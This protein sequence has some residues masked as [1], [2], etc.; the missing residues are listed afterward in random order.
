MK[1]FI[2]K[3]KDYGTGFLICLGVL[4]SGV[5]FNVN[6]QCTSAPYGLYGSITPACTG[7]FETITTCG[8]RGEYSNV[9]VIAGYQYEFQSSIS[10]DYVTIATTSNAPLVWGTQSVVWTATFTGTVRFFNHVNSSC[11]T[12]TSCMTRSVK[13]SGSAGAPCTNNYAYGS[14]SAPSNQSTVTISSCNYQNEYSTVSNLVQ[15]SDYQVN[16]SN[17]GYITVRH[18]AY[19]GTVVAHGPAPL[20]FT[21]T[22]SGTY[23]IHYNTDEFCGTATTCGTT[24]IKCISCG[25]QYNPCLVINDL[26]CGLQEDFTINSGSGAWSNYGGPVVTPGKEEIFRYTPSVSATY[27]LD[28]TS[29]DDW[30]D[31]FYKEA[32][33]GCN[34]AG[35]AY[36]GRIYTQSSFSVAL[37]GGVEYYFMLD[38]ESSDEVPFTVQ[39]GC[40]P[41]NDLC[42]NARS[43]N[44]GCGEIYTDMGST[45]SASNSGA[46][47]GCTTSASTAPGVWYRLLGRGTPLNVSLCGSSFDTKLFVYSGECGNLNCVAGNDNACGV[48]S[49]LNFTSVS[50]ALYY[51]YVTGNNAQ[52]GNY[53]LTITDG[54]TDSEAPVISGDS[55]V[56]PGTE[57]TLTASGGFSGTGADIYWYAQPNG[58]GNILEIGSSLTIVANGTQTFYARREG[59]CNVSGDAMFTVVADVP[60][61][62][63]LDGDSRTCVVNQNGFV[64]FSKDGRLIASVNSHG[65]NLGNV[66]SV[67]YVHGNPIDVPAC[68]NPLSPQFNT[69]VLGRSWLISP[70]FQPASDVTVRLYLDIDE[71][72]ELESQAN[73]NLSEQDDVLSIADLQLSKY[74]NEVVPALENNSPLDNC[75][76]GQTTAHAQLAWDQANNYFIGFDA[77]GYY[78][79]YDIPSFSEFWL[80]GNSTLSPLPVSLTYFDVDCSSGE[81]EIL[82]QTVSENNSDYFSVLRSNDGIEWRELGRIDA[83][84]TSNEELNYRTTD[85][86]TM[87]GIVY[88]K[89]IQVDLDGEATE[90]GPVSAD[91]K[92]VNNDMSIS[93]YPNPANENTL[94]KIENPIRGEGRISL[95]DIS[96][97]A[98][99]NW[100]VQFDQTVYVKSVSCEDFASG[101][102]RVWVVFPDGSAESVIMI[103]N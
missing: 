85:F 64:H 36:L 45:Y 91:C 51:I 84:G 20:S 2:Q 81:A 52:S 54:G 74:H 16:N 100:E 34:A 79:E 43:I 71:Y 90:Y 77:N 24:T 73:I 7:N 66:T 101:A 88:Y 42:E 3:V 99:M 83:A 102:Y 92:V 31:L 48:Q 75:T 1:A 40:P 8:Y 47:P 70:D 28:I 63:G 65:Q 55:P 56:C 38:A 59:Y 41:V 13:C 46:G 37:T 29:A 97:R 23:Y 15:G 17:G 80:H 62:L 61:T 26:S 30:I 5:S 87:E 67:S 21:A 68:Q 6:A 39:L 82:W 72:N 53:V 22:V 14:A 57:V 35:W 19:N 89:L 4:V 32:S 9:S 12:S 18:S 10:T 86:A 103:K 27:V 93:L 60:E 49:E 11:G 96:G 50:G 33:L 94:I 44:L 69:M 78:V 76:S 25:P 95:V 98:V 58:V